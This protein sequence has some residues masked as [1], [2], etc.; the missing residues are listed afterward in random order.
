MKWE[1]CASL[2]ATKRPETCLRVIVHG[3]ISGGADN[4]FL[5]GFAGMR[6]SRSVHIVVS[7]TKGAGEHMRPI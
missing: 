2:E 1:L 5:I 7:G 4:A 3:G 6:G